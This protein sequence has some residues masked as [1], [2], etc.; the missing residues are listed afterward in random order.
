MKTN[1]RT[2]ILVLVVFVLGMG[3]MIWHVEA[4]AQIKEHAH[5][6]KDLRH[7][8]ARI[9]E[10]K[11]A[12]IYFVDLEEDRDAVVRTEHLEIDRVF[13]L[14]EFS[15]THKES[16]TYRILGLGALEG[17]TGVLTFCSVCN[18]ALGMRVGKIELYAQGETK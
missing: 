13:R 15:D 17:S 8:A 9:L 18:R 10:V 2:T 7:F 11:N 14:V 16:G 1:L 4:G 5:R 12:Q 6:T 3:G